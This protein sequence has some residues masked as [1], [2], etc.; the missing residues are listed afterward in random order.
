LNP[1]QSEENLWIKKNWNIHYFEQKNLPIII[2]AIEETNAFSSKYEGRGLRFLDLPL[3]MPHQGW[4]IPPHLSQFREVIG[5]AVTLEYLINPDFEKDNYVY[6]TVDQGIVLPQTSQRRAG[7]HGDS[8]LKINSDNI[9]DRISADSIYISYD[10]CPTPFFAG[11]F[12]LNDIN[13]E[14]I[15]AVLK[16][17]ETISK[18]QK[19]ILFPS[20]MILKMDPYCVHNV[21]IN[22]G[23]DPIYRTFVKI[24]ISKRRYCKLGNAHNQLFTYDWPMVPRYQVPYTLEAIKQSAHRKDRDQ[25][26]EINPRGIDFLGKNTSVSWAKSEIMTVIN[27]NIVQAEL[28]LEGQLIETKIDNFIISMDVAKAGD[29]KVTSSPNNHYLMNTRKF[30]KI[31]EKDEN[32]KG[33]YKTKTIP[34]HAVELTKDV[35]LRAPWGTLQYAKAGDWLIYLNDDDIYAIPLK[36]FLQSYEILDQNKKEKNLL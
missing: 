34:R 36:L 32:N 7:S 17:F 33:S 9:Y 18:K 27:R 30:H 6:I 8:F 3:Y 26:I 2:G 1:H 29:W 21:G 10:S 19:P 23:N 11:P 13:P 31:Y 24:S 4:K 20:Y 15:D 16:E 28:A 35:R 5:K 22:E 12:P 14:N 25:F